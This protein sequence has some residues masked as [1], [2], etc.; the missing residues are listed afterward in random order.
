MVRRVAEKDKDKDGEIVGRVIEQGDCLADVVLRSADPVA[1]LGV[2]MGDAVLGVAAI[3]HADVLG[4]LWAQAM[5]HSA[6]G[7]HEALE[8]AI[9]HLPPPP[10]RAGDIVRPWPGFLS[11]PRNDALVQRVI[12]VCP[13]Q[14]RVDSDGNTPLH[15]AV[16]IADASVAQWLA[17]AG[18]DPHVANK[19]GKSAHDM[20]DT[21]MLEAI[22]RGQAGRMQ[23]LVSEAGAGAGPVNRF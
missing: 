10:W 8:A 6:K 12:Q 3:A 15:V 7:N 20:A 21:R 9:A 13:V 14:V 17:K 4:D 19:E 2:L 22:A 18:A 23:G 11:K 16:S 1:G 5:A